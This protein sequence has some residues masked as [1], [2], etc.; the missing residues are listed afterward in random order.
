MVS[1]KDEVIKEVVGLV[2]AVTS[3]VCVGLAVRMMDEPD[4]VRTAKMRV[5]LSMKEW[6]NRRALELLDLADKADS[7]YEKARL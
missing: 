3:V 6:C 2:F 4:T 5:A 7:M 1:V